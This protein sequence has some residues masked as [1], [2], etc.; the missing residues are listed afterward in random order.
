MLERREQQMLLECE[1]IAKTKLQSLSKQEN[2]L[3]LSEAIPGVL[4]SMFGTSASEL[5]TLIL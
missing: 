3:Y 2:D 1:D 5:T 4:E